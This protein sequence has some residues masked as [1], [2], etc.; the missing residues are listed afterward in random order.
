MIRL[1]G[2]EGLINVGFDMNLSCEFKSI[3]PGKIWHNKK[4]PRHL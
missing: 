4:A 3:P 2:D 1:S